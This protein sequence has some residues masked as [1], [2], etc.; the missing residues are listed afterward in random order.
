MRA[1]GYGLI[2]HAGDCAHTGVCVIILP[3]RLRLTLSHVSRF[4]YGSESECTNSWLY[5]LNVSCELSL[6][7]ST[8]P[9][10]HLFLCSVLAACAWCADKRIIWSSRIQMD[11]QDAGCPKFDHQYKKRDILQLLSWR[12]KSCVNIRLFSTFALITHHPHVCVMFTL[13]R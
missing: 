11:M 4:K 9:L 12:A 7:P 13:S 1:V 5:C 3:G 10:A 6:S 2:L 8:S